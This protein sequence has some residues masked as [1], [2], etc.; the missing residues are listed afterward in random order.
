MCFSQKCIIGQST[1][2]NVKHEQNMNNV[3]LHTV[4]LIALAL[5]SIPVSQ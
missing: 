4:F 5:G 3:S 2:V 1:D